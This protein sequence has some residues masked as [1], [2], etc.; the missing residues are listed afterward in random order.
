VCDHDNKEHH[1]EQEEVRLH[2]PNPQKSTPAGAAMSCALLVDE[3]K[4]KRGSKKRSSTTSQ[5]D[6]QGQRNLPAPRGF[7]GPSTSLRRSQHRWRHP[8]KESATCKCALRQRNVFR[9]IGTPIAFLVAN[10]ALGVDT[11]RPLHPRNTSSWRGQGHVRKENSFTAI[12]GAS[13]TE[14]PHGT[15]DHYASKQDNE[16][17]QQTATRMQEVCK[18]IAS[19]MF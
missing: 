8:G 16:P 14:D 12:N 3:L 13:E 10:A 9:S 15:H 4:A 2:G 7:A 1:C 19:G 17:N 6:K 18:P 5:F 11:D